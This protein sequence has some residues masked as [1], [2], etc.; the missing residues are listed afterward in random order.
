MAAAREGLSGNR[1]VGTCSK[2]AEPARGCA[3][4]CHLTSHISG[5]DAARSLRYGRNRLLVPVLHNLWAAP[6]PLHVVVRTH[7]TATCSPLKEDQIPSKC[8]LSSLATVTYC[9][10]HSR[11]DPLSARETV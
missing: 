1:K 10:G 3:K 2:G 8:C 5:R 7:L 6:W 9:T 11:Q 4:S